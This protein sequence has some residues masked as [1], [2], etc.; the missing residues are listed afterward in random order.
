[1]LLLASLLRFWQL[2]ELP[3]GFYRD[4][5]YNGLDAVDVLAGNREGKNPF[6]F[7]ANNGREPAYIYLTSLA[8]AI[9][10]Q[11]VTAVR[12]TAAVAGTLTTLLV[13]LFA[14]SWFNDRIGLLAALLW[15]ITV[16]PIHLSRVGLR[17]I[18]M[19]MMMAL[20]FWVGTLAYRHST[21]G[22]T[23]VGL[24]L[25]AGL[26]YGAAFYTYLAVRFTPVLLIL[27]LI[28]L[29]FKG[30]RSALLP[31]AGWF[32]LG[33]F[34]TTLPLLYLA[35]QQ[36]ETFLGRAGQVSI[37]NPEISGGESLL[38][39]FGRQFLQAIGLFFVKGDTILRHNP[40]G[41]PVFDLFMAAPF[42]VG[43]VWCLKEWRRPAAM[44]I[45][46]WTL[47][48]LGPTIL[49]EDVPHFLRSVGLLPAIIVFPAIGLEWL[50]QRLRLRPALR[51]VLVAGML[52]GS[53]VFT[54]K[55]Y[56]L[57]YGRQPETAYWF[58]AAARNLA[59]NI[60]A[61]E[62][63]EVNVFLDQRYWDG[64]SAVRF[65]VNSEK[66]VAF[67]RP[68]TVIE[69]QFSPSFVLYV[70]PYDDLEQTLNGIGSGLVN[71]SSGEL[72]Q[73]DL[74]VE[75]YPFYS[76]LTVEPVPDW[77]VLAKFDISIQLRQANMI[78]AAQLQ[79]AEQQGLD[80]QQE[81]KIDLYWSTTDIIEE[82]LVVFVH[83]VGPDGIIAQSDSVPLEGNWPSQWWRPGIILHD[84]HTIDLDAGIDPRQTRIIVGLYHADTTVRLP[85]FRADGTPVGD[86]WLLNP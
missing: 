84:Q 22:K 67:F 55:D 13:Y 57:E 41:R 39:V 64:W 45:L 61:Y 75:P 79:S 5:A 59:E 17:P 27:L 33:A 28:F 29:W 21:V 14:R 35:W 15:A 71:F 11:T 53:L 42:L 6:Y 47:V 48:M 20:V 44:G 85:V 16:W 63:S 30:R 54:I 34:V 83:L 12:I 43:V 81:L 32:V 8:V 18:L 77:P 82:P 80:H 46:L 73:G 9:L 66:Q 70:W 50:W 65:L 69:N 76:R 40:A 51:T 25:L 23:A 3:P 36:P 4:E 38:I 10:G 31:G 62:V 86:A 56:F 52:F 68:E 37:L 72:A 2:G 49:A 26:L 60:N 7:E 19:P 58:E 74:E 1:V 24:W 78:A